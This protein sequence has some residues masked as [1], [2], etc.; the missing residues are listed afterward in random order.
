M[1]DAVAEL[2]QRR[3][4]NVAWILRDEIHANALGPNEA[5]DLLD[6]VEQN[7]WRIGEQ[8]MRFVE[9]ENELGLLGIADLRQALVELG[10]QPEQYRG[11]ELRRVQ[12]PVGRQNVHDAAAAARLQQI[13]DVQHRLADE[14]V[15]TLLLQRQ[16]PALN[17]A[18]RGCRDVPVRRGELRRIVADMRKQRPQ[19]FE[20]EQQQTV[21]VG[22]FERQREDA[23]LC[24]IQFQNARPEERTEIARSGP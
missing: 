1:L 16:E 18:D 14:A 7:F 3:V 20:I 2:S 19:I 5:H 6:L 24:V 11:V 23:G 15:A 21:V 4:R 9:K 8:Q 10:Q 12:Q 13:I 22:K 17:R